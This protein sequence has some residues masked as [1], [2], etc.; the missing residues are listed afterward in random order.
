M[1][2]L[3]IVT[4]AS[5]LLAAIMSAIGAMISSRRGMMKIKR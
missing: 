4:L 2:F 1:M 5:M 3:A